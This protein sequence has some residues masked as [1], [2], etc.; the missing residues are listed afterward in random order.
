MTGVSDLRQFTIEQV[1]VLVEAVQFDSS[2]GLI[3]AIAQDATSGEVLMLAW[4]NREALIETLLTGRVCY[5]SRSRCRL[6]RKGE[7]S[8]HV[9]QLVSLRLD[10]DGDAILLRVNQTGVACHSGRKSCFFL[11]ADKTGWNFIL[12]ILVDMGHNHV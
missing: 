5:W 9:Q 4:M 7:E 8:G 3:A 1:T 12:P 11:E 6:W 2:S 10:C